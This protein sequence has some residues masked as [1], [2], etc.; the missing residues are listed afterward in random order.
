MYLPLNEASF[1]LN[2]SMVFVGQVD[3]FF[4]REHSKNRH[5]II[6]KNKGQELLIQVTYLKKDVSVYF[7]PENSTAFHEMSHWG[8]KR[9]IGIIDTCL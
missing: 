8:D 7:K 4:I 6:H 9:I 2:N 1:L 3:D 5:D